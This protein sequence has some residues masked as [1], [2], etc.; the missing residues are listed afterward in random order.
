MTFRLMGLV[1]LT[2]IPVFVLFLASATAERDRERVSVESDLLRTGAAVA[3]AHGRVLADGRS[4]LE[5]LSHLPDLLHPDPDRCRSV[6]LAFQK[7]HPEFVSMSVVD[8]EGRIACHT[9][10]DAVGLDVSDRSWVRVPLDLGRPGYNILSEG[11]VS[12]VPVIA[13]GVPI[14]A[15]SGGVVGVVSVGLDVGFRN[16]LAPGGDAS[17]YRVELV[18]PGGT[19]LSSFPSDSAVGPPLGR[20]RLEF[21]AAAADSA[22]VEAPGAAGPL[23]AGLVRVPGLDSLAVSVRIPERVAFH[24]LRAAFARNLAAL[25]LVAVLSLLAAWFMA[26]R[27]VASPVQAVADSAARLGAGDLSARARVS[28][29]PREIRTLSRAFDSMAHSLQQRDADIR[30]AQASLA[31]TNRRLAH[32]QRL[33]SVGHLT[34]GIAHDFNNLLTVIQGNLALLLESGFQDAA[35]H[36]Q[37]A[38]DASTRAAELVQRLLSFSRKQNLAPQPLDLHEVALSIVNLLE[39]VL[40][41]TIEIRCTGGPAR[42]SVD[43]SQLESVLVN[44][45]INARDA[46]PRGGKLI[47]HTEVVDVEG[48]EELQ[49]SRYASISVRDTGGGMAEEVAD[50][51]FDPFFTTKPPGKGSG[52]GLSQAWGFARQSGGDLTLDTEMGRGTTVTLYLPAEPSSVA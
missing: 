21:M 43:R 19:V 51:A 46:M 32:A 22:V 13:L 49:A 14:R 3:A 47:I 25:A 28:E 16:R 44:L 1:G 41:E 9:A 18:G 8:R 29:G 17:G 36:V 27:Y 26:T 11:R 24:S 15:P 45:A 7:P 35:G 50:K 48:S 2:L 40:G 30:E 12:G 42:C 20:W 39:R 38:I 37:Q 4:L 23:L 5:G 34:G 10:S 6:L 31:E 52:L 33:E